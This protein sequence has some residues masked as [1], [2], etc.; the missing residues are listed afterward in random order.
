MI[1]KKV[2]VKNKHGIHARPSAQI[3]KFVQDS[4]SEVTISKN[5]VEVPAISVISLLSLGA[6]C[7]TELIIKANGPDEDN[8]I[9]VLGNMIE[10]DFNYSE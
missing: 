8:V 1:E 2:V 5:G 7:G 6:A 4:N 10:S 3:S 9:K